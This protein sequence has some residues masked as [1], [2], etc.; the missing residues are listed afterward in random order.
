MQVSRGHRGSD[1]NLRLFHQDNGKHRSMLRPFAATA[2][3]VS[4]GGFALAQTGDEPIEVLGWAIEP[5]ASVTLAISP[6]RDEAAGRDVEAFTAD[7]FGEL[8]FERV[9]ENG[10]EIGAWIGGR[11]QR[12]HPVR[13]GFSGQIGPDALTFDGLAP[14][15]AF[16]G[17][18]A[19]GVADDTDIRAQLETGFVYVDGG[20]GQL[21]VG[22]DFGVARRFYE[23]SPSVF[24]L[25]TIANARL[26][27]SGI[28]TLLTRNDLTGPATKLSYTSPRLLGLRLGTSYTPR[29]NVSGVDRDPDLVVAGVA[30]PRLENGVEAAFNFRHRF[31]N[32]GVRAESYG[33]YAR[34]DL[35]TGPLRLDTGTVEVWSTG[36]RLAW[37]NLELG[38]DWLTSDNGAGR[39]RAW[40]IGA[41][42]RIFEIDVSAEYGCSFD[43]LTG[44]DGRAWS[45][46]ASKE[47][48]KKVTIT[49]GIQRQ[50]LVS[51]TLDNRAS[52]GP[53]LEMT[54]RY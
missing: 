29:A 10:V 15:G 4:S 19:G 41:A 22:R 7:L 36:G 30:E 3:L 46:G 11:V 34:A 38:A 20:Y 12:D 49:T 24:N 28:A 50:E 5:R 47:F 16:T 21:L 26:D 2:L 48:W 14:R 52:T 13:A 32:W 53:V 1:M 39:Y 51:A 37:E 6:G 17:L 42:S 23:G 27:T 25:H 8:R 54:L 33:A 45:F 35:E 31:R 44:F 9:L 40:S 18:T 43:D